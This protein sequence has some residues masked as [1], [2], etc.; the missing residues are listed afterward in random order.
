ML[1]EQPTDRKQSPPTI[2]T[3]TNTIQKLINGLHKIQIDKIRVMEP[4]SIK[5]LN[6]IYKDIKRFF[7]NGS[8]PISIVLLKGK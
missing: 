8:K 3:V 7:G 2:H 1:I 5:E 6:D 4:E